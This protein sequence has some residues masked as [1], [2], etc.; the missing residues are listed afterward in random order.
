MST[1]VFPLAVGALEFC[2]AVVYASHGQWWAALA[3]AAYAVA[4][5]GL[6][7]SAR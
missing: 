6:A 5:V 2:A 1:M 7:L 4:C 3:W